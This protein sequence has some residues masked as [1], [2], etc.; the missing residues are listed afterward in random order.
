LLE[1]E[2]VVKRKMSED[3]QT[4]IDDADKRRT[5]GGRIDGM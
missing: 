4:L 3:W 5:A 1:E 2:G